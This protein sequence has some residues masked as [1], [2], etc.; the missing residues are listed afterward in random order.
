MDNFNLAWCNTKCD[1]LRFHS[2]SLIHNTVST[3][4]D[5][6]DSEMSFVGHDVGE[7]VSR[8]V[9]LSSLSC[10]EKVEYLTK[11][12]V[13]G[14]KFPLCTQKIGKEGEKGHKTLRFQK[15]W[16]ENCK[17][18]V[19]SPL[20]QGGL[21]KFCVL[22][23]PTNHRITCGVLVTNSMQQIRKATGKDGYLARREKLDYHKDALL[24]GNAASNSI[25]N[26][27]STLHYTL[28]V[29]NKEM[30]D[31]NMKILKFI[32]RTIVFCGKQTLHYA[33]TEMTTRV[34]PQTRE[35][36]ELNCNF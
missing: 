29:T 30:Y 5:A 31:N 26:P 34:L 6:Q 28:S 20:L 15:A 33:A 17:W 23:P 36:S 12:F 22:F 3:Q 24:R 11:H 25:D 2:L 19:Y 18:L 1:I 4:Q 27:T 9:L 35:N 10:K 7:I 8:K 14:E 32:V 16:L 13:P 21:C